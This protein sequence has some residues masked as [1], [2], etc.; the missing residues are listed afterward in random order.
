MLGMKS[1]VCRDE[2]KAFEALCSIESAR[3]QV[4]GYSFRL[5]GMNEII[6]L[7]DRLKYYI[8]SDSIV[9]FTYKNEIE[10]LW[11]IL[12][13]STEIF[14]TCLHKCVPLRGGISFGDFLFDLEKRL[15]VGKPL[16]EAHAISEQ[17]QWI[18]IILSDYVASQSIENNIRGGSGKPIAVD[19]DVEQKDGSFKNNSVINWLATHGGNFTVKPPISV[20]Q[21][22][23]AFES[24]FG[25]YFNLEAKVKIKYENTV[26][27]INTMYKNN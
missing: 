25:E 4:Y 5:E 18:G 16:V 11:A 17:A 3:E 1:A 9:A 27:F 8:F 20:P 19:W 24:L 7:K 23:K 21:F 12:L 26:K 6:P 13:F 14:C 15:F 10:D 22:Y 2:F